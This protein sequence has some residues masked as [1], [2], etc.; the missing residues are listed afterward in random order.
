MT[1]IRYTAGRATPSVVTGHETADR[2][3]AKKVVL[4]VKTGNQDLPDP[5]G[6]EVQTRTNE[7]YNIFAQIMRPT[8]R[9]SIDRL[10]AVWFDT[11]G[12]QPATGYRVRTCNA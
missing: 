9:A 10:L 3:A 1:N 6:I 11:T 7:K 4:Y 12:V 8:V 2:L 5:H